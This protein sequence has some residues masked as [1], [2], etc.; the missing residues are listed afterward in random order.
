MGEM[1]I[2]VDDALLIALKERA[3]VLGTDAERVAADLLQAGLAPKRVDRTSVARSILARAGPSPISS[4]ELLDQ[5][6]DEGR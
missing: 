1:T 5:I 2:R 3:L 6:R 4:T